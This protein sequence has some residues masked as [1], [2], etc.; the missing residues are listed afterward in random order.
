MVRT[1]KLRVLFITSEIYP[2][3]KTGG[4]GDVSAAL[5]MALQH[6]QTDIKILLPGYPSVLQGVKYK[7]AVHEF[8]DLQHFPPATLLSGKLALSKTES[9]PVFVIDCPG[10]YVRE[11]GP[12]LDAQGRD[13]PDNSLR[14]GLLSKIGAILSSDVSPL[15]WRPNIAHCND[16]QS[17]LT[18]AYLHFHPGQKAATV[19]TI[20]NLAFQGVFAPGTVIQL[21]L[22][23]SS[24]NIEGVEYYGNLSFLKAGVY[25]A[26]HITTVSPNYAQ[27]IQ[28]EPLGFG[29]QG[30]LT[31]RN[32][33]LTGIV[34]GIDTDKWNPETDTYLA[35]NYSGEKLSGKIVNK[36]ALQ[37]HM[38]L[39]IDDDIPLLGVISRLSYQ[40]GTDLLIQI[41]PELVKLPAQLVILGSNHVE[42]EQQLMLLAKMYPH[43]IAV[44]TGFDEALSHLIEAGADCFLMPSRFEPCGLNQMYSQHYGTLP[45]V[46]ATGGLLDTVVNYTPS[47]LTKGTASGFLFHPITL[48]S[49]LKAIQFAIDT[50]QNKKTWRKLQRNAMSK[51]FSWQASA[52]A[53]QEI[54]R[55]LIHST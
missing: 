53:Y 3:C 25:Y 12:Y 37:Q 14:F 2:V 39:D 43:A 41:A 31:T 4:L 18:P 6:L 34:N 19:M 49:L 32:D 45:I 1:Q 44:Q 47:S 42:L 16:W 5:P 30:L 13:W 54:Y 7:K 55:S 27:E 21:G 10:L 46:H 28:S 36:K 50:Y 23:S 20:H 17:G 11:G 9:L 35:K 48:D 40:K 51:D 8:N 52:I 33:K 29:M 24:F 15:K 22:P 38:G 26:E